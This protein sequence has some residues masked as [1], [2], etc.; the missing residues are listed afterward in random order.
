MAKLETPHVVDNQTLSKIDD[1]LERAQQLETPRHYCGMSDIAEECWRKGFYNFRNATKKIIPAKNIRA[2]KDG[3]LCEDIMA[4]RLRSLPFIE[5]HTRDPKNHEKQIGFV[6]LLG[7]LRGHCDG[8]IKG[9][10]EAPLTWHVW[11]SKAVGQKYFDELNKIKI[12]VGEKEALKKWKPVYYGQACLYM[13]FSKLT[14]HYTTVMTPGARDHTSMRTEANNA[15]AER[16]IDKAKTII[17]ENFSLPAR[18]SNNREAFGCKWCDHIGVCHDGDFS[19]VHCKSC[20]YRDAIDGGKYQCL[21]NKSIIDDSIMNIGCPSHIFNPTLVPAKLI[22][23]QESG[24]LYM[25]GK[26]VYFSNNNET[27]FPI[28][29]PEIAGKPLEIFTS[30]ELKEK[31]KNVNNIETSVITIVT[32]FSGEVVPE[33][34]VVKKWNCSGHVDARLKD[35]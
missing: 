16:L 10:I 15:Y 13:Y 1:A 34:D 8:I 30:K 27:G 7:H 35:I 24:C 32:A 6:S 22:A 31:I 20:R 23:Q 33:S 3:F 29:H 9:I 2:I 18:L 19:D 4:E 12:E 14:R 28:D 11:E 17:F 25:T 21:N 5:L 26:G